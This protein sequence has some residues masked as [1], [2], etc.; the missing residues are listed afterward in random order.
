[1]MF[2]NDDAAV[3]AR[4]LL[5]LR[6]ARSDVLPSELFSESAWDVLLTAFVASAAGSH[7][8]GHDIART[9]DV[10]PNV[11]SRWIRYLRQRGLLISSQIDSLDYDVILTEPTRATLERLLIDACR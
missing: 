10:A 5:R 6:R 8:T 4:T 11:L 1:M 9:C 7:V 3:V 2:A